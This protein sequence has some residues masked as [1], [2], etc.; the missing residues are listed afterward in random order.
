MDGLLDGVRVLD[1]AVGGGRFA[2]RLLAQLGADVARPDDAAPNAVLDAGK[3]SCPRADATGLLDLAD[4]VV[5]GGTGGRSGTENDAFAPEA[6][7]ANAAQAVVVAVSD[8]GRTGPYRQWRATNATIAA[9]GGALSRN[10]PPGGAPVLPPSWLVPAAA[11]TQAAVA[12]LAGLLRRDRTGEAALFDVSALDCVV[13][14]IDP[15]FGMGGT[16]LQGASGTPD[17]GRPDAAHLY[18][19]F[20]TADGWVRICIL[21]PAQWAALW[22]W[23]GSPAEFADPVY[24]T[25]PGRFAA[26]RHLYPLIAARCAEASTASLLATTERIGLPAAPVV[27]DIAA[28][29]H[30][31]ARQSFVH[32]ADGRRTAANLFEVDG[33]RASVDPPRAMPVEALRSEWRLRDHD[34]AIAAHSAGGAGPLGG[35]LVLDLGV[36]IA[37]GELG[38]T[39]GDL[40]ADVVKIESREHPDGMR[41]RFGDEHMTAS[42]VRGNRGKRSLGIDLRNDRG[43][44][45]FLDLVRRADVLVAN[46]KPGTLESLRLDDDVLRQANPRLVTVQSSAFGATGPWSRR[47]GYGPLVRAVAGVTAEWRWPR[48]SDDGACFG[49]GLTAYPDHLAARTAVLAVLGGLYR[50]CRRSVGASV[51]VAQAEIALAHRDLAEGASQR[52]VVLP[53]AG[54]D[55]WCVVDLAHRD[56]LLS[57]TGAATQDEFEAWVAAR[58]PDDVAQVL[59]RA[60]IAAAPMRRNADLPGDPHLAARHRFTTVDQHGFGDP[61]TVNAGPLV[62]DAG[63]LGTR[64]TP[65]PRLGE[66]TVAVCQDLLNLDAGRVAELVADDIL[67]V[68]Q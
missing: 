9:L 55:E 37:G 4:I 30:F 60:A 66:H 64:T 8:F 6:L 17:R 56:A 19:V 49:D 7:R 11:G 5:V 14:L 28:V 1:L 32:T 31:R 39:L 47:L 29:A 35:L 65:A 20:A 61:V 54:D 50:S 53:C 24:A 46:F 25:I 38:R 41:Q 44:S 40:G 36:I 21:S 63:T 45:L 13:E 52:D 59:Q 26:R 62:S 2:S 22:R 12:A 57:A 18:P 10:G 48:S 34:A 33:V 3:R 58:S 67:H 23:L 27:A 16:A 43:R 51:H 15:P 42:F 68:A